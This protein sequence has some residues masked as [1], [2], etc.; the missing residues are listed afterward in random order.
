[1]SVD[2]HLR[3]G[4]R[5]AAAAVTPDTVSALRE[6][7]RRATRRRR[8]VLVARIAVAAAVTAVIFSA[9]PIVVDRLRAPEQVAPA[10]APASLVGT[11]VVDVEDLAASHD[12]G[13]AGRWMVTLRA[14]G[15]VELVAPDGYPHNALSGTYRI[16]DDM[17]RTDL[18]LD[19]PGCQLG[20]G[21]VASYRWVR[22][23]GDLRFF[24]VRDTCLAQ[25]VL[26]MPQPWVKSP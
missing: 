14:D 9:G 23:E 22:T 10:A 25:Q 4:L 24:A 7:R 16:E 3:N 6:V 1:M 11:Y 15:V 13:M 21:G 19:V 18:F 8:T 2:S 20:D 5:G 12:L 17:L 26:F